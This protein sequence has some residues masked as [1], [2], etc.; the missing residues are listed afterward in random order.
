MAKLNAANYSD[1][2]VMDAF[3]SDSAFTMPGSGLMTYLQA[4]LELQLVTYRQDAILFYEEVELI[5]IVKAV[6]FFVVFLTL[7]LV[8]LIKLLLILKAEVLLTRG[9]L[10]MIPRFVIE[11][12]LQVQNKVWQ[13]RYVT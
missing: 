13:R 8:I 2:T 10:N 7:Y 1:E 12:N 11:A 6:C 9:M 4:A 3:A 5:V